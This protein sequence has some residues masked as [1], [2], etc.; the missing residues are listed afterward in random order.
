MELTAALEFAAHHRDTLL[1][2]LRRDGRP[3]QSVVNYLLEGSTFTISITDTRAKTRNLRRDPRAA[4]WVAGSGPYEWVSFDGTVSLSPVAT[5]PDDATSDELVDYYRLAA[6][7]HE[8]WEE[9]REAMVA[10]G[11]LLA[12]FTAMSATGMLS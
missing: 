2:T 1:T 4:L 11:R 5:S 3:Q 7:E 10:D 12:R 8:N 6:G 9:Y